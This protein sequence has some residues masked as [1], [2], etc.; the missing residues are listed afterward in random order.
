MLAPEVGSVGLC[1]CYTLKHMHVCVTVS[2][3]ASGS[4]RPTVRRSQDVFTRRRVN[5]YFDYA[6]T[7]LRVMLRVRA[8]FGECDGN[9]RACL[10]AYVC[11]AC[12]CDLMTS[13]TLKQQPPLD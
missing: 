4:R 12:V 11:G 7:R 9:V 10:R 2:A 8:Q 3:M 13:G 6:F 1:L 5:V